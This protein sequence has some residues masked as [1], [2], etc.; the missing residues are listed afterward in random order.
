LGFRMSKRKKNY[1]QEQATFE[2]SIAQN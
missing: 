1:V 2:N